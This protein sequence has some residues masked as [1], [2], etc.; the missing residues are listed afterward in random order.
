MGHETTSSSFALN[1]GCQDKVWVAALFGN[2]APQEQPL[3]LLGVEV[4]ASASASARKSA[5]EGTAS[6][7]KL[8]RLTTLFSLQGLQSGC[9][10]QVPHSRRA[11]SR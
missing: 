6:E 9:P 3:L 1:L 5:Q 10:V 7:L 4:S 8:T 2:S 11:A